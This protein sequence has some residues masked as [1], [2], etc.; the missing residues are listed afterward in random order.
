M[1]NTVVFCAIIKTIKKELDIM[2]DVSSLVLERSVDSDV[3]VAVGAC[4]SCCWSWSC[5]C[6]CCCCCTSGSECLLVEDDE[7]V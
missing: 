2:L 7:L 1:Q 6:S 4:C 3:P 5:S